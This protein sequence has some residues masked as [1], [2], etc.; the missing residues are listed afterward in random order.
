MKT[1]ILAALIGAAV[2]IFGLGNASAAPA[3]GTAIR[4]VASTPALAQTVFYRRWHRERRRWR[5]CEYGRCW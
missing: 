2:G 5:H 4:N 1:I 3:N